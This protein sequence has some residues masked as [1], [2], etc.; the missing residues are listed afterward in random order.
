M[1]Y[2]KKNDERKILE[3]ELSSFQP[4]TVWLTASTDRVQPRELAYAEG[5]TRY[6]R[7]LADGA[8]LRSSLNDRG[9]AVDLRTA[10]HSVAALS[11][12]I[13]SLIKFSVI[14]G[15]VMLARRRNS[16][17]L[18]LKTAIKPGPDNIPCA[19]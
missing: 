12:G 13:G 8:H 10:A 18:L 11:S 19:F 2:W 3:V 7:M 16:T 17:V 1:K 4:S 14:E 6:L 5:R 15:S 9:I